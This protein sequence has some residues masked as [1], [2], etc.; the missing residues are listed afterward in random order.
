MYSV[1]T[2]LTS[3]RGLSFTE[4]TYQLLQAYDFY[5]LRKH[6]GCSIQVGGSDQWGNILAGIE[7]IGRLDNPSASEQS[8]ETESKAFGLTTPLLTTASGEKFGKSAGNAVWL[9][10]N[11]TSVFDF[12]Q[13]FFKVDDADVEKHLKL[14]TLLTHSEISTVMEAHTTRPESRIAQRRLAA[15]V[16]EMVHTDKG[17]TRAQTLTNLLFE[18]NYDGLTV[19]QITFAFEEDPR[20]VMVDEEELLDSP[21]MKLAAR[22]RLV[23][24]ASASRNLVQARGL[25]VNNRTVLESLYKITKPELIDGRV[26]ILRAGK[27]KLLILVTNT[28]QTSPSPTL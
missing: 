9:D 15:E 5:H 8:S 20:L 16:T 17:L 1:R 23:S 13:Y 2:R 14:F 12:Y 21:I 24:S 4:F 26:A 18:S 28:S 11:M 19:N 7:L 3:Q 6:F 27:D 22:Y 25:Y 10:E